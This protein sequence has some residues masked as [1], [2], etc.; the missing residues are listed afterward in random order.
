MGAEEVTRFYGCKLTSTNSAKQHK[1]RKLIAG[2]S[3]KEAREK[4]FI[5]LYIPSQASVDAVVEDLKKQEENCNSVVKGEKSAPK[6]SSQKRDQLPKSA[7][8]SAEKW[9]GDLRRRLFSEWNWERSLQ[10]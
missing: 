3:D 9:T 4:E 8:G 1:L 5:S 7:E 6:R 2:L 10:R